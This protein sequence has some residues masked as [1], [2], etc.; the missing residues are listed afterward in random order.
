M[1]EIKLQYPITVDGEEVAVL[2]MRRPKVKDQLAA[3]KTTG[4]DAEKEIRMFAN[5]CDI[6]P[7]ALDELDLADY[8]K[9]QEVFTGFLS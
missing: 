4:T 5:L 8:V 7:S 6:A 1:T 9:L 3:D 2:T